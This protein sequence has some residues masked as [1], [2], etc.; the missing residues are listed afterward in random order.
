MEPCYPTVS[1]SELGFLMAVYM[2]GLMGA[3]PIGGF[4]EDFYEWVR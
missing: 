4:L 2:E 3:I 1:C